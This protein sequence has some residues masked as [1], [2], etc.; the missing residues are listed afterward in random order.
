MPVFEYTASD[1][2]GSLTKG[3]VEATDKAS[4]SR[5][6]GSQGLFVLE[7]KKLAATAAVAPPP[8]TATAPATVSAPALKTTAPPASKS[9]PDKETVPSKSRRRPRWPG[10]QQALYLRQL[11]VLFAA[12]IPIHH[13]AGIVGD[14]DE[15]RPEIKTLLNQIPRDLERG[16]LLS[17][18]LE[19]SG[20]FGKLVV[21]SVRLGEESGRLQ[22]IL[23]SLA[24]SKEKSVRLKRTLVSRLTYPAVVLVVMSLG[25]VIM[26]HVMS[27]VMTSI[28]NFHPGDVPVFGQLNLLF[29]H[30]AFLPGL[31]LGALL[32]T[33]LG[34]HIWTTPELRL[35]V[36]E[37]L[38]ALPLVGSLLKR[39]EANAVTSQ[40]EL[41][42]SAGLPIVR[43]L[44]LCA[45]LVW[46]ESYRQALLRTRKELLD[47]A[48]L[49][50]CF[51]KAG[52]FPQDVMALIAAGEASGNLT[53]SLSKA[54]EYCADQVERTLESL[55]AL[56]EPLLIGFLGITI[57]AVL[58]CTFVP[59]F[60]NLQTL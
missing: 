41:L 43:G 38:I 58:L 3:E 30:W 40:L 37:R 17:K 16:R 54:A 42:L 8:P 5:L 22:D 32:L 39:L 21:S 45:E 20:L 1:R 13:A 49:S 29:R 19:R 35:V 56:L 51:R 4:A 46:T 48:E 60:N 36:E 28:P 7:I 47:G 24:E 44:D 15:H 9:S 23:Q 52:L 55:L 53:S 11:Q 31:T 6:L 10:V 25:L 34:R 33:F 27:R 57:G 26:G 59:V 50:D 2:T 12:G 14:S 18:S